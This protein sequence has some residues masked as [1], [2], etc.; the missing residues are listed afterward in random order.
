MRKSKLTRKQKEHIAA[1]L[2]ILP[3]FLG[4]A[5]FYIVPY[6]ICFTKSLYVGDTFVGIENYIQLFQNNTFLLALKNTGIFTVTAIPLL[7]VISFLIALFLNSFNKISSFF[8]SALLIP[9]VV[10]IASLKKEDIL[11]K[12]LRNNAIKNEITINNGIAV[13]E[14]M[15]VFLSASKNVLF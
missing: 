1:Y 8:R 11:L 2:F 3:S 6:I 15:P 14:N 4:I 13:T 10:P 7:M 5:V 9:V 12:E